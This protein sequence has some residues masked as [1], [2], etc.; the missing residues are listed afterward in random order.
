MK[1][2]NI[3]LIIFT[4]EAL[5][6]FVQPLPSLK[7]RLNYLL[8]VLITLCSGH[9]NTVKAPQMIC[10]P[11]LLQMLFSIFNTSERTTCQPLTH[12]IFI[13]VTLPIVGSQTIS[14]Q[15][16]C[17]RPRVLGKHC[18]R[19]PALGCDPLFPDCLM[20]CVEYFE[21]NSNVLLLSTSSSFLCQTHSIDNI[22]CKH[23][24]AWSFFSLPFSLISSG[25]RFSHP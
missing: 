15:M 17:P 2:Y 4:F 20:Q 3:C 23:F 12:K 9:A 16:R 22:E 11:V 7:G 6:Q 25:K 13:L 1:H 8:L 18:S 10:S 14:S 21:L 5:S 24:T 19:T